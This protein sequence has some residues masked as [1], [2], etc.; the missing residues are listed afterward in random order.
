M[1][2][3]DSEHVPRLRKVEAH[4]L[5]HLRHLHKVEALEALRDSTLT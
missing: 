4:V 2:L 5:K 1:R 3:K